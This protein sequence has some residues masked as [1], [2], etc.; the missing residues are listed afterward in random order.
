[1]KKIISYI[2]PSV[3]AL[4]LLNG[5]TKE[6]NL[7][8]G[9][10]NDQAYVSF[11][12]VAPVGKVVNIL[13]DGK[14]AN[15]L[16]A[17][18][19]NTTTNGIGST[20]ATQGVYGYL[21]LQPGSHSI[22]VRDTTSSSTIDYVTT[23]ISVEGGK[24]YSA[25][26]YD[27]L[28]NNKLKALVLPTDRTPLASDKAG[29]RF[30]HLIP[31]APPVDVWLFRRNGTAIVDSSRV[32]SSINYVG[33]TPVLPVITPFTPVTAA[34][35]NIVIRRAGT[36]VTVASITGANLVN[37]K[38]YTLYARGLAGGSGSTAIGANLLLHN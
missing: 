25:F 10:V 16:T 5:C 30:L 37:T 14:K 33:P 36:F 22:V 15:L 4:A 31:N 13:V 27:T 8:G 9:I 12:H 35:Y 1:M 32:F 34:T 3:T 29:I 7:N 6:K 2:I 26:V 38:V 19:Y 23:N 11:T 24:S 17:L 18:T 21:A 28:V 20:S